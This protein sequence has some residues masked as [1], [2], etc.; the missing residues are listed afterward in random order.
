MSVVRSVM[1]T[2]GA[3]LVAV[4]AITAP[5]EAVI[6][7]DSTW[8]REG[9]TK[10][11]PTKGYAAHFRL[12]ADPRFNS[13]LALGSDDESWGEA[14]GTWIGNDERHAYI[15]TAAHVFD[16]PGSPSD[17]LVR[18]GDGTPLRPDKLWIHPKWTGD[19]DNQTGFD[20][21][22]LRLPAPITNLGPAPALYA[23]N[24]ERGKLITFMGF[25]T[26]GIG[27]KG[28]KENEDD[29]LVQRAA[30]QGV[31]DDW[32]QP[33][34]KP[35]K[36]TAA[37]D[38]LTVFLPKEDGSIENP[39]GGSDRPANRLVGLLGSGDSGGSAWMPIG[40]GS[41]WAIVGV[42]SSGDGDGAYGDS[43]WFCRV[44]G[45]AQWIS[46]IFPGVQFAR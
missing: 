26:R 46:S 31:V 3:A 5:A 33:V 19:V 38:F 41:R 2:L 37:G 17:Y 7:L 9:G 32:T 14:S 24:D 28:D 30:A 36:G 11:D 29:D 8:K 10:A 1:R 44:S 16:L 40:D 27:S 6:V 45:N 13:V 43:S 42:N 20:L 25:G 18:G 12:A 23:G 39:W 15:L 34:A 22:I 4:V 35:R 21:A